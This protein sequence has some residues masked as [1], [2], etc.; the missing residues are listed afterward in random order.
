MYP[1]LVKYIFHKFVFFC[2]SSCDCCSAG[3]YRSKRTVVVDLGGAIRLS[4]RKEADYRT[5]GC[6]AFS[7]SVDLMLIVAGELFFRFSC[8]NTTYIYIYI[9]IFLSNFFNW[10]LGFSTNYDEKC[11]ECRG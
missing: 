4:I 6:N 1:S 7:R 8:V 3:D 2:N 5:G 9:I 11:S 10:G